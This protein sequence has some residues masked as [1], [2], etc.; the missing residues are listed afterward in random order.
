MSRG[1]DIP[2]EEYTTPNLLTVGPKDSAQKIKSLMDENSVRHIPV[3]NDGDIVGIV[4]DR[5]L[6][7]L[8][9][10]LESFDSVTADLIMRKNPFTVMPDTP[11]SEVVYNMSDRKIGS[12]LVHDKSANFLGIFTSTDALNALLELLQGQAGPNS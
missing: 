12:A 1:L 4:S 3:L 6:K 9:G 7:L 10:F 5:D 11:L 8:D 2:V